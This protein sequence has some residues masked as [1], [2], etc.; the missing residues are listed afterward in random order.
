VSVILEIKKEIN[1]MW[2]NNKMYHLDAS[3]GD[4]VKGR[5]IMRVTQRQIQKIKVCFRFQTG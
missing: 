5:N 2:R 3:E 1:F 4:Y